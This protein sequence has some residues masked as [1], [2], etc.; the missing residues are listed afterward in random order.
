MSD[1]VKI[2]QFKITGPDPHCRLKIKANASLWGNA[3][4]H[5]LDE[6]VCL[7]DVVPVRLTYKS[8]GPGDFGGGDLSVGHELTFKTMRAGTHVGL[9]FYF[10]K[11]R[12]FETNIDGVS[13]IGRGDNEVKV[14]V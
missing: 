5:D 3:A 6:P 4:D 2:R 10:S 7:S 11:G 9:R 12:F 8:N 13:V 14:R 1:L